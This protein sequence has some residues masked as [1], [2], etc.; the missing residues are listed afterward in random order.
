MKSSL[1]EIAAAGTRD[2]PVHLLRLAHVT[3]WLRV[4]YHEKKSKPNFASKYALESSRRDLHN[5]PLHSSKIQNFQKIARIF[6]NFSKIL[7]NFGKF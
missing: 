1:S 6:H 7:K 5:A 4:K 3:F 2:S